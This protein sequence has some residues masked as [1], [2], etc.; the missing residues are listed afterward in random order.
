VTLAN[1]YG[2]GYT[3]EWPPKTLGLSPDVFGA[4]MII[5]AALWHNGIILGDGLPVIA[6][7][8]G[9]VG[10]ANL[11][12]LGQP[13]NVKWDKSGDGV[14]IWGEALR[15]LKLPEAFKTDT[16]HGGIPE[17]H[18]RIPVGKQVNLEART[19]KTGS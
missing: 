1:D 3:Q 11:I 6:H 19:V 10:V 17:W 5:D 8:P 15:K 4:A 9:A 18:G 2:E 12:T 16:R 14:T 7:V 13:I